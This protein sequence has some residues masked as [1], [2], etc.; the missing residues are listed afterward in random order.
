MSG[1]AG[2]RTW[3]PARARSRWANTWSAMARSG[4]TRP[5]TISRIGSAMTMS[6]RSKAATTAWSGAASAGASVMIRT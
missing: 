5:A 2:T 4:S 3:V 6:I 1:P